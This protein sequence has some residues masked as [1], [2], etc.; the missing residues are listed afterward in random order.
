MNKVTLSVAALAAISV[1]VQMQAAELTQTEKDANKVVKEEIQYQIDLAINYIG[2]NCPDVS[3][4]Y[5]N[6]LSTLTADLIKDAESIVLTETVKKVYLDN[7]QAIRDEAVQAQKPYTSYNNIITEWNKL[8]KEYTKAT[9]AV[10]ATSSDEKD[11]FRVYKLNELKSFGVEA[12]KTKIDGYDLTKQDIVTDEKS[13]KATIAATLKNV[14]DAV[15]DLDTQKSTFNTNE[16]NY[17]EIAKGIAAAKSLYNEKV[18]EAI[19]KLSGVYADWQELAKADLK[20]MYAEISDVETLN[21]SKDSHANASKYYGAN[22]DALE[23]ITGKLNT[24]LSIYLQNKTKQEGYKTQ[25]DA[26]ITNTGKTGFQDRLDAVKTD[27]KKNKVTSLDGDVTT[28]QGLIDTLKAKLQGYY[29][30]HQTQNIA[31]DASYKDS[32]IGDKLT[33]LETAA[34]PLVANYKAY[35]VMTKSIAEV[36]KTFDAAKKKATETLSADKKYNAGDHMTEYGGTIQNSINTLTSTVE[37][38]YKAVEAVKYQSTFSTS[39]IETSITT[40]G[41]Y[42]GNALAAYNAASE[43]VSKA[44]PELE[45]LI[46]VSKE[47]TNVTVDGTVAG[48]SYASVIA[49]LQKEIKNIN[50]TIA[51]ANTL[52]GEKHM[53]KM[54]AT[55][56]LTCTDV[57]KWNTEEAY[58]ANQ[59]LFVKNNGIAAATNI[60]N[61]VTELKATLSSTIEKAKGSVDELGNQYDNINKEVERLKGLVDK[62]EDPEWD[63]EAKDA[64]EKAADVVAKLTPK[65]NEL[66]KLQ[67]DVDK[68]FA[69]AEAAKANKK[70]YDEVLTKVT[71]VTTEKGK[72]ETSLNSGTYSSYYTTQ[73]TKYGETDLN[74]I[75]KDEI[76]PAYKDIKMVEKKD[77]II[78]KLDVLINNIKGLPALAKENNTANKALTDKYN[79]VVKAYD[80]AYKYISENDKTSEGATYLSEL[81]AV[82]TGLDTLNLNITN[83]YNQGLSKSKQQATL[84]A[85]DAKNE[86]IKSIQDRQKAGYNEAIAADNKA[87]HDTF[88]TTWNNAYSAFQKAVTILDQFTHITNEALSVAKENLNATHTNIMEYADKLNKLMADE[89]VAYQKVSSPDFYNSFDFRTEANG[90]KTKINEEIAAY[91]KKVNDVAKSLYQTEINNANTA[92]S[93]AKSAISTY[94]KTVKDNA[95]ADVKKDIEDAKK[96]LDNSDSMFAVK[97]DEWLPTF[98]GLDKKLTNDKEKAADAEF[99]LCYEKAMEVYSADKEAIAKLG[100]IKNQTYLTALDSRKKSYIDAAKKSYDSSKDNTFSQLTAILNKLNNIYTVAYNTVTGVKEKKT[101]V[102]AAAEKEADANGKNLEAYNVLTQQ[103]AD[104]ET[105][106]DKVVD[107]IAGLVVYGQIGEVFTAAQDIYS[108]ID[109]KAKDIETW[110]TNKQCVAQ[111]DAKAIEVTF[112]NAND[113]KVIDLKKSINGAEYTALQAEIKRID[114]YYNKAAATDL[115]AVKEY[116]E[117][118][119]QLSKTIDAINKAYVY[120]NNYSKTI[121]AYL[122]VQDTIAQYDKTLAEIADAAACQKVADEIK[123]DI[124]PAEKALNAAVAKAK[125]DKVIEKQYGLRADEITATLNEIK[126]G[127]DNTLA[128]GTILLF[129]N[130]FYSALE[131]LVAEKTTKL[132]K[133]V[134]SIYDAHKTNDE[135]YSKLLKKLNDASDKLAE[136]SMEIAEYNYLDEWTTDVPENYFDVEEGGIMPLEETEVKTITI[137]M[138]QYMETEMRRAMEY[139]ALYLEGQNEDY[140]L[141]NEKTDGDFKLPAE[142][143]YCINNYSSKID[144]YLKLASHQE[145]VRGVEAITDANEALFDAVATADNY[146]PTAFAELDET[147]KNIKKLSELAKNYE[148][149]VYTGKSIVTGIDGEILNNGKPKTY[150]YLTEAW[151]KVKS[152]LA[153]LT[154][155]IAQFSDDVFAKSYLLGDA[156]KDGKVN[157]KDYDEV[158]NMIFNGVEYEDIE[159]EAVRLSADANEDKAINVADLSVISNIIF[160]PEAVSTTPVRRSSYLN[161]KVNVGELTTA[162]ESEET[163]I[164]GKTVRIALNVNSE[165][166]MTNGQMDITLPAGMKLAGVS[167]SARTEN[168][169]V[170]ASEIAEGVQRVLITSF[171][172]KAIEGTTGA[173]AYLDV[174]IESGYNGGD[175]TVQNILFTDSKARSLA[176]TNNGGNATTGIDSIQAATVKER[177]YSVGGQMKKALQRGLNIIVGENGEA[178]TVLKK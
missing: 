152:R 72:T 97:L 95:F 158:R 19:T 169:A 96:A 105:A 30:K 63:S 18:Q 148:D 34:Q 58:K 48:D 44:Q 5:Q 144:D 142:S 111:K 156:N 69:A 56:K 163:T 53:L 155:A 87:Q 40:Y 3:T 167:A 107:E 147:Y 39:K 29:E 86:A 71:A 160:K 54:Q 130:N 137:P 50:D 89:N 99:T 79:A 120:E 62:V 135:V 76:E 59:E 65:Y 6:R 139:S 83:Y 108:D 153:E 13:I 100:N 60:V 51:L 114:E 145:T 128:D 106:Y 149:S 92:L 172:N 176:L 78:S 49:Q 94:H 70:A 35:D 80:A 68:L 47:D 46:E 170:A 162:V 1:P 93:S 31:S 116:T 159:D 126:A 168:H 146:G 26:E 14:Q 91:Q 42:A 150:K 141:T 157:V 22:K 104:I 41:T 119:A 113:S 103:L 177:I 38:K 45:K 164:F 28:I 12:I 138:T 67:P 175:I 15:K 7:V 4:E 11:A 124:A 10:K 84:D 109:S 166:E 136:V 55:G 127:V 64:Y 66:L 132:E 61:K 90:Y 174:E 85:L 82:K 101:S 154:L 140:A 32:K 115:N 134:K 122:L 16:A 2:K 117:K 21:G 27:L 133:D 57:S 129:K 121:Q 143:E 73:N 112:K 165:E 24:A 20:K 52:D 75:K 77:G 81:A 131:K 102:R 125:Y 118:I 178:K 23:I 161:N 171:E 88:V 123:V 17:N 36:Q 110:K 37:S 33:K 173:V 98:E 74:K 43:K 25:Y 8:D 151:P 9:D